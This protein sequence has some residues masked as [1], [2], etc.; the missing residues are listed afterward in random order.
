ML[1]QQLRSMTLQLR[2]SDLRNI[3]FLRYVSG[4][5]RYPLSHQ[6]SFQRF[7]TTKSSSHPHLTSPS[8]NSIDILSLPNKFLQMEEKLAIQAKIIAYLSSK[9]PLT[10]ISER[11]KSLWDRVVHMKHFIL[12]H[13]HGHFSANK[14]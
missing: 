1:E 2:K 13:I 12:N 5:L 10:N 3:E 14:T 6:I 4:I 7:R 11:L 9:L 8:K